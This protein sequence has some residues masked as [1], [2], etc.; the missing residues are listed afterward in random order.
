MAHVTDIEASLQKLTPS[1]AAFKAIETGH[2][3]SRPFVR[4]VTY[5]TLLAF[6]AVGLLGFF[7]II[8][9]QHWQSGSSPPLIISVLF[10]VVGAFFLISS[11]RNT[12]WGRPV[13]I[14][15]SDNHLAMATLDFRHS[16]VLPL[17]DIYAIRI[18]QGKDN[19]ALYIELKWKP[20]FRSPAFKRP[21]SSFIWPIVLDNL[22]S[23]AR[24]LAATSQC[25]LLL[26]SGLKTANIEFN[27][28]IPK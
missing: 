12:I 19:Q 18:L 2:V 5:F 10:V 23:F 14:A 26:Q 6:I 20:S 4:L 11:I 16:A 17:A 3:K 9:P 8:E 25:P 1:D 15:F 13:Y 24:E 27:Q 21:R 7:G 28:G 22:E